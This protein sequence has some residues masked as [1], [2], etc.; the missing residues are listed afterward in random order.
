MIDFDG[1]ITEVETTFVNLSD[2]KLIEIIKL[3]KIEAKECE[4]ENP[5]R[6]HKLYR[7]CTVG[8]T[9]LQ[10]RARRRRHPKI[11][12]AAVADSVV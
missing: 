6:A 7:A 9:I 10:Y 12:S 1:E 3:I 5:K 8:T 4:K 2:Q 11:G